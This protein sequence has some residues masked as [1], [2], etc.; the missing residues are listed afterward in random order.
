MAQKKLKSESPT[1]LLSVQRSYSLLSGRGDFGRWRGDMLFD[2][3]FLCFGVRARPWR[4]RGSSTA[5][6]RLPSPLSEAR[7][8]ADDTWV[9]DLSFFLRLPLPLP[10]LLLLVCFLPDETLLRLFSV[11]ESG[12]CGKL[13]AI[14]EH[15][16]RYGSC[17]NI[18]KTDQ[19][20][21]SGL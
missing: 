16:T 20:R 2:F 19:L 21:R 15:A 1:S 3:E 6:V 12:V 14:R 18:S 17:F 11:S 13:G 10:P 9:A 8:D 5:R 4:L 7:T